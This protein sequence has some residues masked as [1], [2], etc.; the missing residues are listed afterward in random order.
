[1]VIGYA[2]GVGGWG[3]LCYMKK[4]TAQPPPL[5]Y[6]E[7]LSA[8]EINSFCFCKT[9]FIITLSSNALL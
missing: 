5:T 8:P 9:T 1:M 4:I 7:K 6:N 3:G 2:Y